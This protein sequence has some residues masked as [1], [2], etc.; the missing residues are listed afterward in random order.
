METNYNLSHVWILVAVVAFAIAT[1]FAIR[2]IVDEKSQ[3][4]GWKA[5]WVGMLLFFP[6]IGMLAWLFSPHGPRS[7]RAR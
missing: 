3:T 5:F 4:T 2:R 7:K 6:V 1:L